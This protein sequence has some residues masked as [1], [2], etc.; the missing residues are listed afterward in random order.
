VLCPARISC[1]LHV[2][3]LINACIRQHCS[4][5]YASSLILL[6]LSYALLLLYA[7]VFDSNV[8]NGQCYQSNFLLLL[9]VVQCSIVN[10]QSQAMTDDGLLGAVPAVLLNQ[11][12][13]AASAACSKCCSR[14]A[15]Q[16][17][18]HTHTFLVHI[19]KGGS[20]WC[21]CMQ[22]CRAAA[23]KM[24][25]ISAC[26][27]ITEKVCKGQ[28]TVVTLKLDQSSKQWSKHMHEACATY[29]CDWHW[30]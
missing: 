18:R 30:C 28:H 10:Q 16:S 6:P 4:C 17:D 19:H 15:G 8:V 3:F 9:T 1:H 27:H 23:A 26:M 29:Q 14:A 2:Y 20:K 12:M 24:M 11:I 5:L 22:A 25:Q 13:L 7:L 21:V